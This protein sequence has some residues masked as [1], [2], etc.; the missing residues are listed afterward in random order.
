MKLNGT[1]L[2]EIGKGTARA[3][4]RVRARALVARRGLAVSGA[5][6]E[7]VI[8]AMAAARVQIVVLRCAYVSSV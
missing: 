3:R 1:L 5:D 7:N 8:K 2:A 4:A 6:T